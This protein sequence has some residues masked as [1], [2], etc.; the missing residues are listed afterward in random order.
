[1]RRPTTH[2]D[3]RRYGRR[4][5][6]PRR[7]T[8]RRLRHPQD[9]GQLPRTIERLAASW[10]RA[11]AASAKPS[12]AKASK[13]PDGQAGADESS[14]ERCGPA[15]GHAALEPER[16]GLT[17]GRDSLRGRSRLRSRRRRERRDRG[18]A[19]RIVDGG[20]QVSCRR[21]FDDPG[22][23]GHPACRCRACTPRA[24]TSTTKGWSRRVEALAASRAMFDGR[25]ATSRPLRRRPAAAHVRDRVGMPI[26]I[27]MP[28]LSPT[29]EK[30]NLAKWHV[31]E[32]DRVKLRRRDRRD[33]DR[34]G[35]DGGRGGRRGHGRQD[36]GGR[37][38]RRTCRSTRDRGAG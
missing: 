13:R 6:R 21:G 15:G 8:K 10:L 22:M 32:G 5:S 11:A 4:Q 7:G 29:M 19:R 2:L 25:A 28:A 27:L 9:L 16:R 24:G 35:D 18:A 23:L 14:A 12:A 33:R 30:G 3:A 36:R 17:D 38:H 34:Q 37:G 31:K 1:M 20:L 26:N